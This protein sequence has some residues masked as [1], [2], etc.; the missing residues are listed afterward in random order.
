M[1]SSRKKKLKRCPFFLLTTQCGTGSMQDS[2]TRSL[3]CARKESSNIDEVSIRRECSHG[4]QTVRTHVVAKGE[5]AI[6]NLRPDPHKNKCVI[7]TAIRNP[8]TWLPSIFMQRRGDLCDVDMSYEDFYKEYHSFLM[9]DTDNKRKMNMV[10]P[11]LLEEFGT[12]MKSASAQAKLNGGYAL[13]NTFGKTSGSFQN[14]ELLFLNLDFHDNWP[15]IFATLYPGISYEIN[16][17]RSDLCPKIADH[18]EKIQ[19]HIF[20]DEEKASLIG[21]NDGAKDYFNAFEF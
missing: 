19:N 16:Q 12:D 4:G 10:R 3:G 21:R 5:E 8:Q 1:S 7:T 18:Y 6:E 9:N 13:Y 20:T 14:C 2:F 15:D 11:K 17:S